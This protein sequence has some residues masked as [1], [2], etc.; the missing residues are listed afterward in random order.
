MEQTKVFLSA[1]KDRRGVF[2]HASGNHIDK[3][4]CAATASLMYDPR[5]SAFHWT[6]T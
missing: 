4:R 1:D 2:G 6:A 3:D 5:S